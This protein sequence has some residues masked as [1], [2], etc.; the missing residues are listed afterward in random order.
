L[1]AGANYTIAYTGADFVIT[2]K[3]LV[4]TADA[5][6]NKVYGASDPIF[7]Y[8]AN[9]FE[10]GDDASILTGALTRTSGE[11]VGNYAINQGAL[12]AGDNYSINYTGADFAITLKTLVVTAD[13]SQTKVYGAADPIF[14]Y[15]VTG[16]ENGDDASIL[17]G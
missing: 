9:G 8:T 4:V 10:N 6:Q 12:N 14:S 17:T 13:A 3:T 11:N 16:F 7:T 2:L 15:A 5:N 1:D